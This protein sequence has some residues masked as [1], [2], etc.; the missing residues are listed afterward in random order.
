MNI[1][2]ALFYDKLLG[3]NKRWRFQTFQMVICFK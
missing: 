3:E 1:E 2:F